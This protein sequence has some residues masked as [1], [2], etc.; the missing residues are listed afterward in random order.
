MERE[1]DEAVKT[2]EVREIAQDA[3]AEAA[4]KIAGETVAMVITDE[5]A[6]GR[7]DVNPWLAGD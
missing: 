5:D 2:W 6:G 1:L 7:D 4:R 3:V